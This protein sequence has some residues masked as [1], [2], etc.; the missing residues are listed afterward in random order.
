VC[1]KGEALGMRLISREKTH[2]ELS[3]AEERE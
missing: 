2:V 1:Q 3:R